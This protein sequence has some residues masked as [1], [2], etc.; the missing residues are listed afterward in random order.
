M[1]DRKRFPGRESF[2]S[3][4]PSW[5]GREV[6]PGD[7]PLFGPIAS[8]GR[9]MKLVVGALLLVLLALGAALAIKRQQMAETLARSAQEVE[10]PAL[11]LPGAAAYSDLPLA[12]P[13][14][15]ASEAVQSVPSSAPAT[16]ADAAPAG[17]AAPPLQAVMPPEADSVRAAAPEPL[18][19]EE[20]ANARRRKSQVLIFDAGSPSDAP[21]PAD[22]AP[23]VIGGGERRQP[24]A[25]PAPRLP[26]LSLSRGTLIPAV[27]ESTIDTSVP[28]SVR[29]MVS[30]D[31]RAP[32]GTRVLVPRASRL[33]GQYRGGSKSEGGRAYVIWTRIE[34]PDGSRIPLG[35]P[36][37]AGAAQFAAHYAQAPVVSLVD[38]G[39]S[40]VRVRPGEPIR[41]MTA[42]TVA[43]PRT[44]R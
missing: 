32:D 41:V 4:D 37:S 22:V 11:P 5:R 31:V 7:S 29:A 8:S 39:A 21:A 30:V 18:P 38:G 16:A 44:G 13:T 33:V 15:P 12:L 3:P 23:A 28:G 26:G 25:A 2:D 6:A 20:S 17:L 27:L 10:G 19:G 34:R 40:A 43:L 42:R 14:T 35:A 9:V 1:A 24:L 36:P